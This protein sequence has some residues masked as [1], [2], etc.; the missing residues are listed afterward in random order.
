[1]TKIPRGGNEYLKILL[2]IPGTSFSLKA[3]TCLSKSLNMLV[4]CIVDN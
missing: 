2:N 4:S 3:N 1:M